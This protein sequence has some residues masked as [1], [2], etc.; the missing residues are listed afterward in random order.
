MHT[1]L[2]M[3]NTQPIQQLAIKVAIIVE[4]SHLMNKLLINNEPK[5][6]PTNRCDHSREAQQ[7]KV[8]NI[9]QQRE[10]IQVC[11]EEVL[12]YKL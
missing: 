10:S 4:D 5:R 12:Y 11:A 3:D 9:P 1:V 2:E 8:S 7:E 6:N